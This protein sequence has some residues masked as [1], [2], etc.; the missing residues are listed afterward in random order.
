MRKSVRLTKQLIAELEKHGNVFNACGKLGLATSTYYRWLKEDTIFKSKATEAIE[1]GR[2]NMTDFAES[3]LLQNIQ[4]GDQRAVEFQLKGNDRR[5]MPMNHKN[6]TEAIEKYRKENDMSEK[7]EKID[8]LITGLHTMN[9]SD[10]IMH[11]AKKLAPHDDYSLENRPRNVS[12]K[13]YIGGMLASELIQQLA[14][15]YGD[16][17]GRIVGT[18]QIRPYWGFRR[19]DKYADGHDEDSQCALYYNKTH[20]TYRTGEEYKEVRRE[21]IR[22][23]NRDHGIPENEGVDF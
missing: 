17:L 21:E 2:L 13:S 3:K 8:Y 14:R 6:L 5:Y 15:D 7:M 11:F 12:E 19:A 9:D 22:K 18:E 4:A 10:T 1:I 23:F 16:K 20:K